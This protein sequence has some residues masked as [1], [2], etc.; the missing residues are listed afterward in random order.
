M[1]GFSLPPLFAIAL[2]FLA[3]V[4]CSNPAATLSGT[5][6]GLQANTIWSSVATSSDGT[7]IVATVDGGDIF[8]SP[9][10]GTTWVDH[11]STGP[12]HWLTVASS[13]NGSY[14][15][16]AENTSTGSVWTSP[17][18]GTTWL[19]QPGAGYRNWSGVAASSDGSL[20]AAAEPHG[21][22]YTSTNFGANWTSHVV[23]TPA[24]SVIFGNIACSTD[25]Q[26]LIVADAQTSGGVWLSKDG[27]TTWNNV[28]QGLQSNGWSSVA[29]S[30]N[31]R[32]LVATARNSGGVWVSTNGG[33][34]WAV[35]STPP[36]NASWS[37]AATNG[38]NSDVITIFATAIGGQYWRGNYYTS[39]GVRW[40][41][42]TSLSS[43][44][45]MFSLAS[46][47]IGTRLLVAAE[48]GG[49]LL[50]STDY[51]TTWVQH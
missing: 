8:T 10:S 33:T 36:Q 1:N 40:V 25:G 35:A 49:R 2:L 45:P 6:R 16:A 22:V 7:H 12:R 11:T 46:A 29:S 20:L 47:A 19:S 48:Y 3:A 42:G 41:Q 17:D 24:Y 44:V 31:G 5:A 18:G 28:G 23:A 34:N 51:G 32:I 39:G 37:A 14:L 13:L 27:G 4:S 9:D 43:T 21:T 50:T 15:V 30:Y 26:V 38:G